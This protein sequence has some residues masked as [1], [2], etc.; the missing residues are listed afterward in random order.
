MGTM[1][2]KR[3]FNINLHISPFI[4]GAT[5]RL[6]SGQFRTLRRNSAGI[7]YF[8]LLKRK[9]DQSGTGLIDVINYL[10]DDIHHRL[11]RDSELLFPRSRPLSV[12]IIINL[13][14]TRYSNS[15]PRADGIAGP[16]IITGHSSPAA[17]Y[18]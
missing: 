16:R 9:R 5:Q 10:F 1:D 14:P 3:D 18:R 17:A 7:F 15:S 4:D 8:I 2:V 13:L 12:L 11:V 6:C